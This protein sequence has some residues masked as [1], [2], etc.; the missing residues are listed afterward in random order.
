MISLAYLAVRVTSY[1]HAITSRRNAIVGSSRWAFSAGRH[2]KELPP[3]NVPSTLKD[4][5][6]GG[7]CT[8][9][10]SQHVVVGR[11]HAWRDAVLSTRSASAISGH[12][13]HNGGFAA[14][15]GGSHFT[16]GHG[17]ASIG[18]WRLVQV[19]PLDNVPDALKDC[20]PLATD[21][22]PQKLQYT[23]AHTHMIFGPLS[24]NAVIGVV[25][26]KT[27]VQATL[28]GCAQNFACGLA[29][30]RKKNFHLL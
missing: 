4:G 27:E 6:T 12:A 30:K 24:S 8:S 9:T 11:R 10:A 21:L 23:H 13:I 15:T 26:N 14:T 17:N 20:I 29:T 1:R 7:H 16:A 19:A 28:K 3:N 2:T 25:H 5:I 22:R 18:G